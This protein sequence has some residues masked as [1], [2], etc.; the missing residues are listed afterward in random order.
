MAYTYSIEQLVKPVTTE[1]AKTSIYNV[2]AV[3]GVSTTSWQPGAI[4]RAMIAAVAI[5]IAFVSRVISQIAKGGFLEY[6]SGSWLTLLAKHV[7]GV[8]R[9]Q[10]TYASGEVTLTNTGGGVYV[11]GADDLILTNLD[12]GKNYRNTAGFTLNALDDVTIS[13][14]A[15]EAGSDSTSVAG[16]ITGFVT[17]LLGV[18]A[19]NALA[20]VGEDEETDSALK[21]RCLEKLGA[22]SPN[23]PSDA[24]SYVAKGAK[25]ADGTLINVTRTRS[26]P[27]G[28]GNIDLYVATASGAVT[29]TSGDASTDLGAVALA[30]QT[31]AVPLCVTC[32]VYSATPVTINVAGDIYMYNT[33]GRTNAEV[34]AEAE[35]ALATFMSTQPIGGNVIGVSTGKVYLNRLEA[36]IVRSLPGEIF[37]VTLTSPAADVELGVNEVPVLGS[38]NLNPIQLSP[39]DRN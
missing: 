25:A 14:A 6:S 24:Y 16:A 17:P 39:T 15:V 7:Y 33:S 19:A 3:L 37:Q 36:E 9:V 32:N 35:S 26:D 20:V 1:E 11:L 21:T 8:E 38:V 30:I 34:Q 12:T 23:G 13:I 27:D 2:L 4:V 29:G 10:A 5:I 18:T 22:L 28:D 31:S